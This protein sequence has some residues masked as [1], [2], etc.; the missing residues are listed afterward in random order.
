[1]SRSEQV[2]E[3]CIKVVTAGTSGLK[4]LKL[5]FD[6]LLGLEKSS[7]LVRIMISGLCKYVLSGPS[8]PLVE[9][10][11]DRREERILG[12][13]NIGALVRLIFGDRRYGVE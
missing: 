1:M 12:K 7:Q 10:E 6:Y 3:T 11:E 13:K 2:T 9:K 4:I 8:L 5:G